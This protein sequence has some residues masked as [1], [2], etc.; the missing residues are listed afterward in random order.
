MS[1]DDDCDDEFEHV[2]RRMAEKES[3]RRVSADITK[4]LFFVN[5]AERV[6]AAD[7]EMCGHSFYVEPCHLAALMDVDCDAAN[8]RRDVPPPL[9]FAKPKMILESLRQD[10]YFLG[11][12]ESAAKRTCEQ[13]RDADV[14]LQKWLA[15][16][17]PFVIDPGLCDAIRKRMVDRA[18]L[19]AVPKRVMR[20]LSFM[21][22]GIERFGAA[23]EG[24]GMS[25]APGDP[26]Q[27]MFDLT[28]CPSEV[29]QLIQRVFETA[30]TSMPHILGGWPSS[31]GASAE[32]EG[33]DVHVSCDPAAVASVSPSDDQVRWLAQN[34]AVVSNVLCCMAR[35]DMCR[36]CPVSVDM[37]VKFTAVL[38]RSLLMSGAATLVQLYAWVRVLAVMEA[39]GV[40]LPSHVFP[41]TRDRP[42]FPLTDTG[43]IVLFAS[44]EQEKRTNVIL[45][46]EARDAD[47][48]WLDAES[49]QG[50]EQSPEQSS[51]ETDPLNVMK[52][53]IERANAHEGGRVCISINGFDKLAPSLDKAVQLEKHWLCG[54][55]LLPFVEKDFCHQ[56]NKIASV[57]TMRRRHRQGGGGPAAPPPPEQPSSASAASAKD[58]GGADKPVDG[59]GDGRK[60]GKASK[61]P[62]AKGKDD[63][64][65][66]VDRIRRICDEVIVTM[67]RE[68]VSQIDRMGTYVSIPHIPGY[69]ADR[70]LMLGMPYVV[71]RLEFY[72]PMAVDTLGQMAM[73]RAMQSFG[74]TAKQSESMTHFQRGD[75]LTEWIGELLQ[76]LMMKPT[77]TP[78]IL[79]RTT[80]T[81]K[82]QNICN[83]VLHALTQINTLAAII[84]DCLRVRAHRMFVKKTAAAS[85]EKREQLVKH[86][87]LF[88]AGFFRGHPLS[89][90]QQVLPFTVRILECEKKQQN[91]KVLIAKIKQK[92]GE[93]GPDSRIEEMLK[94]AVDNLVT[95]QKEQE[96]IMKERNTFLQTYKPTILLLAEHCTSLS[97]TFRSI[98][99]VFP[100]DGGK[101]QKQPIGEEMLKRRERQKERQQKADQTG[102]DK[103]GQPDK[104][105]LSAAKADKLMAE[106]IRQDEAARGRG[107]AQH[108]HHGGKKGKDKPGRRKGGTGSSGQSR[109]INTTADTQ[110]AADTE[111]DEPSDRGELPATA[112]SASRHDEGEDPLQLS[113]ASVSADQSGEDEGGEWEA[114]VQR[115]RGKKANKP[116]KDPSEG[117]S[118]VATPVSAS[119]MTTRSTAAQSPHSSLH[120]AA[121]SQTHPPATNSTTL[122]TSSSS[123]P[124][125]GSAAA[126]RKA[127]KHT[128]GPKGRT[129]GVR[130]LLSSRGGGASSDEEQWYLGHVF[131][132][133]PTQCEGGTPLDGEA[134]QM[135]TA[136]AHWQDRHNPTPT[137]SSSSHTWVEVDQSSTRRD[138]VRAMEESSDA[139]KESLGASDE[140]GQLEEL[141]VPDASK[142]FRMAIDWAA[143]AGKLW[144]SLQIKQDGKGGLIEAFA[145]R[146]ETMSTPDPPPETTGV[147]SPASAVAA[148][149][150]P[151]SP[152]APPPAP[153][154]QPPT[155]APKQRPRADQPPQK[156]KGMPNGV[157]QGQPTTNGNAPASRA[158]QSS[159]VWVDGPGPPPPT[160]PAST[161]AAGEATPRPQPHKQQQGGDSIDAAS[162]WPELSA[163]PPPVTPSSRVPARRGSAQPSPAAPPPK[164]KEKDKAKAG[165]RRQEGGQSQ[166]QPQPQQPVPVQERIGWAGW[167]K[168]RVL[169]P[170]WLS[171]S[172][173]ASLPHTGAAFSVL[174]RLL[175]WGVTQTFTVRADQLEAFERLRLYHYEQY[176]HRRVQHLLMSRV[177][178]SSRPLS[179]AEAREVAMER[180]MFI[181]QQC[182]RP[183]Q[184]R[185]LENVKNY[186]YLN[187]L[188]QAMM[189]LYF[190]LDYIQQCAEGPA[191]RSYLDGPPEVRRPQY[192]LHAAFASIFREFYRSA[193]G[194]A[195][196]DRPGNPIQDTTDAVIRLFADEEP[197]I[198]EQLSGS[199]VSQPS[200]SS[201]NAVSGSQQQQQPQQAALFA[202]AF[203]RRPIAMFEE[204]DSDAVSYGGV[205]SDPSEFLLFLLD[206]L[207]HESRYKRQKRT[208]AKKPPAAL[209][210]AAVS[211]ADGSPNAARPPLSPSDE[212]LQ[213]A[214]SSPISK[215]FAG[216][217]ARLVR[218]DG[219]GT[220]MKREPFWLLD[221][222]IAADGIRTVEDAISITLGMTGD[223]EG[224]P[225]QLNAARQYLHV[226][227]PVLVVSMKKTLYGAGSLE[228]AS[229]Q[230]EYSD[231]LNFN[232]NWLPPDGYG[233]GG[234]S[235]VG[236]PDYRLVSVVVHYGEE[237]VEGHFSAF[238]NRG[239]GQWYNCDDRLIAKYTHTQVESH[240]G[241]LLL[242]YVDANRTTVDITPPPREAGP[243]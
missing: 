15:S 211:S 212:T 33:Q 242:F 201:A 4:E 27:D 240:A 158:E 81:E 217:L 43:R 147:S 173:M 137:S 17:L 236:V 128:G 140:D 219:G 82:A 113:L 206:G 237:A 21:Q 111:D 168:R 123:R 172:V 16:E 83:T 162:A 92:G 202:S 23:L 76:D 199:G 46:A 42:A 213:D 56:A 91:Q 144:V 96:Q 181:L 54:D 205:Q 154:T 155:V 177:A 218:G 220:E 135:L 72:M 7:P 143:S 84:H 95:L 30:V 238:V 87:R 239:D 80:D 44:P 57:I 234:D 229:K 167:G 223:V 126:N 192:P 70:V 216:E 136:L 48:E 115:G 139:L 49:D 165:N 183:Y 153:A 159:F 119:A 2:L 189:P 89:D 163:Q 116:K 40:R 118:A 156:E 138:L 66:D 200:S 100:D 104:P 188:V 124:A 39:E 120:Q 141:R 150:P 175:Y 207:H 3:E 10:P 9:V 59:G 14:P 151:T 176:L 209:A 65:V 62:A 41:L 85:D 101:K 235:G 98:D 224:D 169:S 174:T 29:F 160:Q 8:P 178:E 170:V 31:T 222:A 12:M 88:H 130:E 187:A 134:C 196:R 233:F 45:V 194:R 129:V 37:V 18:A 171:N 93:S 102:D 186:C 103:A 232:R 157:H 148:S 122:P 78:S 164:E 166:E 28:K 203:F 230:V 227:P 6:K 64:Q 179:A 34:A 146:R 11:V 208:A 26:R 13:F 5:L 161:A 60:K 52:L 132:I 190:F 109:D 133:S 221:V 243:C 25:M 73:H 114:V 99:D 127:A 149:P 210:E 58:R 90:S 97:N 112:P 36:I 215:L 35:P 105:P 180:W 195:R 47:S 106:L 121:L 32:V 94:K 75:K 214:Q 24:S 77:G 184:L 125:T 63:K 145:L 226:T 68:C 131:S 69:E 67:C 231:T 193:D 74:M 152:P 142:T 22:G 182:P 198:A 117:S 107:A 71:L 228:K 241:A 110:A 38:H 51:E 191:D 20:V 86:S 55:N 19:S 204:K 185:A 61:G 197:S 1:A 53:I 108:P 50:D 225:S 79:A